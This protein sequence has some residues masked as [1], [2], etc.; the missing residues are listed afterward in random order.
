M[1]VLALSRPH[2]NLVKK[3]DLKSVKKELVFER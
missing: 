1:L 3:I 2:Q